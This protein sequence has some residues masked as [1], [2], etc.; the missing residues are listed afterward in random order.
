MYL[1]RGTPPP[2]FLKKKQEYTGHTSG[3]TIYESR[4]GYRIQKAKIEIEK[5]LE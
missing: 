5:H 4:L 2:D 3:K 1:G